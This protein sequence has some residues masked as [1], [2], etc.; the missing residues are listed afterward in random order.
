[1]VFFGLMTNRRNIFTD[2]KK[3]YMG[4]HPG[5]QVVAQHNN[6][7]NAVADNYKEAKVCLIVHAFSSKS[8]GEIHRLSEFA[9]F[10]CIP[11]M[12]K[13]GDEFGVDRYESCSGA[14]FVNDRYNIMQTAADVVTDIDQGLY[15]GRERDIVNWWKTGIHWDDLLTTV[16][17]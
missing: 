4:S 7:M 10:G 17:L 11:V 13:W 16:M 6:D 1:M 15:I 3:V 14:V 8:A 5:R 9:P 12:E 2:I